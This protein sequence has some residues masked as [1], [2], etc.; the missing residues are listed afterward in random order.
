MSFRELAPPAERAQARAAAAAAAAAAEE[1]D[2]EQRAEESHEQGGGVVL[3][4]RTRPHNEGGAGGSPAAARDASHSDSF[5]FYFDGADP[6]PPATRHQPPPCPQHLTDRKRAGLCA[7][8]G[9][10]REEAQTARAR[11][12]EAACS[13]DCW[14][15]H[16]VYLQARFP[17]LVETTAN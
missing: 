4:K 17:V 6:C 16:V 7:A 2:Q 11:G 10:S 1:A 13:E 5:A 3:Q 12:R 14:R 8:C 9:P 15:R